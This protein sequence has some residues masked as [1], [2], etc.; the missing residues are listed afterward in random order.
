MADVFQGGAHCSDYSVVLL[1]LCLAR[2]EEKGPQWMLCVLCH[3]LNTSVS[4]RRSSSSVYAENILHMFLFFPLG[5]LI[6]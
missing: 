5:L 1:P 3:L 6:I 2:R 4:A